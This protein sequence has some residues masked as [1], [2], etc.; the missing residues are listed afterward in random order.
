MKIMVNPISMV[1]RTLIMW[2]FLYPVQRSARTVP[3]ALGFW[4]VKRMSNCFG[5]SDSI[6]QMSW[7]YFSM[8][9]LIRVMSTALWTGW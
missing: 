2:V 1:S 5:R 7:E 3:G 9:S 6:D 8:L 4:G